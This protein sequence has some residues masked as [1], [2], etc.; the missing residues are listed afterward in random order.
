MS[1]TK[2]SAGTTK[3][4][5]EGSRSPT[6]VAMTNPVYA[7]AGATSAASMTPSSAR[8]QVNGEGS[9][10]LRPVVTD[11]PREHPSG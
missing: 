5:P 2:A 4:P 6:V 10:A 1:A 11:R 9:P 8:R 7:P 3:A